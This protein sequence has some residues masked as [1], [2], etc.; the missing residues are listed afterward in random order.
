MGIMAFGVGVGGAGTFAAL[1]QALNHS[2]TKGMLFLTAGNLL[3]AYKTKAA[4]EVR[5]ILDSVPASGVLWL[6]GFLAITGTP[7]FGLFIS[8]FTILQAA[9]GTGNTLPGVLYLLF[10][11]VVFIG[12]ASIFL[13][14]A[15]GKTD[16]LSAGVVKPEP[17]LLILPPAI[18]AAAT[19]FLG[20][21]LPAGLKDF[22]LRTAQAIGGAP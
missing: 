15:A 11:T 2:L 17:W 13:P 4:G 18:L 14:M 12:M 9:F 1:L 5:G 20:V 3:A 19:L 7:P 22:L 16:R 8:E 10:L 21:Y 6:A